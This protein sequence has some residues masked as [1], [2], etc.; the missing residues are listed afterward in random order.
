LAL[1]S[2]CGTEF[3][4]LSKWMLVASLTSIAAGPLFPWLLNWFHG[5]EAAAAFQA[6]MNVVGLVNPIIV[7]IPAIVMP[8]AAT[9]VLS[10]RGRQDV[11]SLSGLTMKYV[12]QFELLLAPWLLA[13]MFWPHRLLTLFYGK[14]TVYG[15][16]TSTL[17]MGVAV[18][19]L[20][21]PMTV[22]GAVL[23]GSGK[24]KGNAIMQGTGAAASLICAPPLIFAGGVGGA[25]L[26]EV[27]TRGVRVVAAVRLLASAQSADP[28]ATGKRELP[29]V[30]VEAPI[31]GDQP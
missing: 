9:Y 12:M 6:V 31:F 16:Q 19:I 5:R 20:T 21:V 10:P 4:K 29:T 30:P 14:A 28:V 11:T 25:M 24:T 22:L 8:V 15:A 2:E 23:T 1:L 27:V 7:S 3:W 26:S 13:L 17:R 18:Y